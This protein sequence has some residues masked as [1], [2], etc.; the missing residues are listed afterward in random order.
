M[1]D[2]NFLFSTPVYNAMNQG[3][4]ARKERLNMRLILIVVKYGTSSATIKPTGGSKVKMTTRKQRIANA[5]WS[6]SLPFLNVKKLEIPVVSETPAVKIA[7][8]L[9]RD[10]IVV[11]LA[12]KQDC[13]QD[14]GF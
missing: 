4:N 11:I 1:V 10:S 8:T 6:F 13:E 5:K 7:K 9:Y 2:C 14:F 12:V 3:R